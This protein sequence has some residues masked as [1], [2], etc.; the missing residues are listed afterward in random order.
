MVIVRNA[1]TIVVKVEKNSKKKCKWNGQENVS[2]VNIPKVYEP[3]PIK[4]WEKCFACG[5]SGNIHIPH[6]TNV[7]EASEKD[8]CQ[9][10]A[11]VFQKF[12]NISFEEIA[13]AQFP[14]DP[15][16]HENK[17]CHHNGKIGGCISYL[18]PLSSQNLNTLLKV[19]TS[20]IKAEDVA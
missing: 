7:H 6:M 4:R 5:K 1:L 11:V 9:R 17:K 3:R 18:S 12:T 19:D 10:S 8:N 2:D 13:V 14:A 20:D 15:C 16:A